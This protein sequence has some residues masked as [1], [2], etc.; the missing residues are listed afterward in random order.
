MRCRK[1]TKKLSAFLDGE[2]GE[3]EKGRI[4]S[5]LRTCHSCGE[6][7]KALSSLGSLLK[8]ERENIK[9]SPYFWNKLEQRIAQA[10]G[11][12]KVFEKLLE[13]LN[14]VFVPATA[15]AILLI[16]IFIGSQLGA[17]VYSAIAK[18]LNPESFATVQMEVDQSLHL[19]T[20]DDFPQESI[21]GV[22]TALITESRSPQGR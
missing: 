9:P 2:A 3:K 1:V 16:G 13:R 20:L 15:S 6:E 10:E 8:E 14:R 21:G 5:H 7:A 17:V 12:Q 19:N 4:T 18:S 11:Q 22:Y